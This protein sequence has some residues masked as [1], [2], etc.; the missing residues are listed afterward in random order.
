MTHIFETA[1]IALKT[2]KMRTI[3]TLLGIVIGIA[4]II[5]VMS[6]GKG[7]EEMILSQIRGLGS[8]TISIEPGRQPQGPA[9]FAEMFTNSLKERELKALE[10]IPGILSLAPMVMV[11]GSASY[12]GEVFQATI[13]GADPAITE[14][15]NISPREGVFFSKED[16][17]QMA[18]VV[19]IGSKVKKEL[20]GEENALGEKI[21]IK[22]RKFR[23]IGTIEPKG[24]VGMLNV[25]EMAV[26]PYTTAQHYILGIDH[27]Q[28]ITVQAQSEALIPFV[29]EDIQNILRALHN[30]TDPKKDD[31]HIETQAE[32]AEKVKTIMGIM[33]ALLSSVAAISLIVGGIGIMNIMLVSVTERT[34]EIGL[35]KA[36]GARNKD[37]LIQFLIESIILTSLGGILGIISGAGFAFIASVILSKTVA[38]AWLFALPISAVIL[39]LAVSSIIGLIFGIYPA[40]KAAKLNPIEALR[41]E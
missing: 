33:T 21:K 24:H 6:V 10:K 8:Q 39:G 20:F 7:A 41:Y 15:L 14:M 16:V 37:I 36:I 4:S 9:D 27:F 1:F 28:A 3:L 12:Q 32:A 29:I 18:S 34:R 19:V 13:L 30:I 22:N 2:N 26:V 17:R 35:R 5:L 25:D 11:P 38:S 23:I 31:F 40:K